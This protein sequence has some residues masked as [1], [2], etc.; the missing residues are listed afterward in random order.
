MTH[1]AFE[2]TGSTTVPSLNLTLQQYRHR[3]TGARHLHLAASDSNNAFLVAFPTVPQ[4]STGVAHILEHTTLCGSRRFPVRD[5]FFLMTRRSLNTFMNAFTAADWTAYPFATQNPK[6]FN[7]LLQVYLD[8]VFFPRLDPLDFAQ[9]GHRVEFSE[10]GNPDTELVYKGVVFNEMKGAMSSPLSQVWQ[11]LQSALFPTTTYHYNSGGDPE[12][13]PDLTYEQLK[14]FHAA[15]YHPS[16]A[17]FVTYGNLPAADH[18]ATVEVAVLG[19]FRRQDFDLA[20]PDERRYGQPQR[21]QGSYTFDARED[22]AHKT[23]L[24]LGWLLG[25]TA[26]LPELMRAHLLTGVLMDNSSS[27]LRH[28]LE[29]TDLGTSPSELCGLDDSL[30]EAAFVCGLEGSDP[31]KADAVE[32]LV[33]EVLQQVAEEG[34]PREQVESVLHQVELSQ[35]EIGGGRVPYG[36]QLMLR[37]LPAALH[38]ADPAAVLDLDPVLEDL[39]REVED[40]A[41]IPRLTRQLLLENAHRVRLTMVPDAALTARRAAAEAERL[42]AIKGALGADERSALVERA[43]I[44]KARQERADD[45]EILPKVGLADVP[46]EL[47]IPEGRAQP[48]AQVPVT[49]FSQGTNGLVYLQAAVELPQLAPDLLDDLPLYCEIATEV[50]VGSRD[51]RETQAWQA[52]VSGGLSA[53]TSLRSEIGD[54]RRARGV[55]VLATKG[56]TRHQEAVADL[57]WE[58]LWNARFDEHRRLRELVAQ[59]RAQQEGALTDHGHVLAMTAACAGMGPCGVIAHQWD[60]LEGIRRLKARDKALADNHS[61][62]ALGERLTRIRDAIVAGP[63]QL[64]AVAE[65][66]VHAD[67]GRTLERRWGQAPGA[68]RSWLPLSPPGADFVVHQ[69]WRTA[70]EVSFCAK[71]YPTVPQNHPDAPALTVLGPFLRNGFLH[72]AIR[73]QGGAYG[74]GAGYSPDTGAFRFYSYRDPR[75]AGTLQD[76]DRSLEWLQVNRHE[77]RQLEEAVLNVISE[78]DRPDSPAAEAISTFFATLHGRTPEQRRLFRHS[79]LR[80]S[81]ADLQ[82]VGRAYLRPERASVAVVSSQEALERDRAL[83]LELHT[84]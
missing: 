52:A 24:V 84:V 6:D 28:A 81:L 65:E 23:H 53:R 16:N 78:I 11:A 21:V 38:G 14:A 80:V 25:K 32:R 74:A 59:L 22:P 40:P 56:L 29:T 64:V 10:P 37:A 49:W 66:Q 35:R 69:G 42:A 33:L 67:L 73:E 27:P 70:A 75:L 15:H 51:Y 41:F 39:R 60:G 54:V 58:T 8:A 20:I 61:L 45:P 12:R 47:K 63:M 13:I 36:L 31:D 7:N 46:D 2:L 34:V 71:A 57:L 44:L 79:I 9:E 19:Q 18:Q 76:F 48:A 17:V 1:P 3:S 43:A 50:G 68:G 62:A 55:F 5:P 82:R 26:D 30:R 83:G 4:D 77:P 72:R